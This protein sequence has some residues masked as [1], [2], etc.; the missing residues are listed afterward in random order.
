MR[1]GVLG[2][3]TVGRTLA[4][5]LTRAGHHVVMGSRSAGNETAAAWVAAQHGAAGAGTF[6]DA[7]QHG[8]VLVNATAGAA[9]V[10]AIGSVGG[11]RP[12]RQGPRRRGQ[13]ARLLH[14]AAA[15]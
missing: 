12:G 11:G 6:A 4:T 15:G 14:G 1:I 5:A 10:E 3:G 13:P 8:V 2:T 9:S 7:A